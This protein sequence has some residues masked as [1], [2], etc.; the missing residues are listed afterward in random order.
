MKPPKHLIWLDLETTGLDPMTDLVLEVYACAASFERPLSLEGPSVHV[1]FPFKDWDDVDPVVIAMHAKS[2]LLA[3]C[4]VVGSEYGRV[5]AASDSLLFDTF[6]SLGTDEDKLV[7]A[8]SSVHFDLAF[9]RR[10]FPRFASLL[11]HRV[12][13]VSAQQLFCYALGMPEIPK[14]DEGLAHRAEADVR[15]SVERA[16]SLMNWI[17]RLGWME[18]A[19]GKKS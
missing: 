13:D 12:F 17:R 7:L 16:A 8:G 11:S 10:Y 19:D 1:V 15:A 14:G 6:Q 4:A 2:G 5:Y 3:E 9:V 18:P